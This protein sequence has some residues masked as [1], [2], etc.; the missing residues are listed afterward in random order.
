MALRTQTINGLKAPSIALILLAG[1]A[2]HPILAVT[3]LCKA[4]AIWS[5]SLKT[6]LLLGHNTFVVNGCNFK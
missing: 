3:L 4:L 1:L 2:V 5:K 6:D